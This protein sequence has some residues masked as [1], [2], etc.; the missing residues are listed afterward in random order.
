MNNFFKELLKRNNLKQ[1]ELAQILGISVAAVSQ[2]NA[3]G[4]IRPEI[5]YNLSKLFSISVDNLLQE[6]FNDESIEE[7]FDRLYN[8]DDYDFRTII[9][10]NDGEAL[11]TFSVKLR[12][13]NEK[14]FE[15]LYLK[16]AKKINAAEQEELNYLEKYIEADVYKSPYFAK[17]TSFYCYGAERDSKIAKQ[18]SEFIDITEKE[19]F[20]WELKKIYYCKKKIDW[21]NILENHEKIK[22][23]LTNEIIENLL[24]SYPEIEKD[25]IVM[26]YRDGLN[27]DM[28]NWLVSLGANIIYRYNDLNVEFFDEEDLNEFEG[29]K[30]PVPELGE[31]RL[32]VEKSI[33]NINL[34]GCKEYKKIIYKKEIKRIKYM[35]YMQTNPI[36]HWEYF[37]EELY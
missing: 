8:L 12:N 29:V 7:K 25:S 18:I 20:V 23:I 11:A 36:K 13:I 34:L 28:C 4:N 31:I 26:Q 19:E 16:M 10:K 15:L 35:K 32:L 30:I 6:K 37:K 14:V 27:W 24:L 3:A 22:N 1:T 2:W 17:V 9:N 5:L 33:N 21:K